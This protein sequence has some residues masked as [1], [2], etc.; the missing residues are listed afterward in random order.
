MA[1]NDNPHVMRFID[2]MTSHGE[3]EAAA[4]FAGEHPLDASAGPE[5]EFEWAGDLCSFL[6][7]N[8]DD[9]TVKAV[10][11]DCACGPEPDFADQL[12]AVY[13]KDT[14]PD[15]FVDNINKL[16]LGL[17]LEY[18]GDAYYLIYPECYCAC[19]NTNPAKVSKAWCYCTLG[20]TR[21]LFGTI[22]GK[23]VSVK[24]INSIKLGDETCRIKIK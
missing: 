8:Y 23:D 1:A 12:K 9:E 11:M 6:E 14:D 22:F 21:C 7:S 5:K 3:K 2:S 19:V 18:D 10:R 4:K 24:L 20:Y 13:E 15:K 17:S 16:D